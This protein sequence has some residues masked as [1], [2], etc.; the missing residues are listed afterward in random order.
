MGNNANDFIIDI[1]SNYMDDG[2][3]IKV[4]VTVD[5]LDIPTV[6]DLD[7]DDPGPE[8]T[9]AILFAAH[10]ALLRN[11]RVGLDRD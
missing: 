7:S 1:E 6:Y 2:R 4:E 11:E 9:G 10:Q 8:V 5:T 3:K